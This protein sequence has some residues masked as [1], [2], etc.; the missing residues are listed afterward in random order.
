MIDDDDLLRHSL[1]FNLE[2]ARYRVSPAASAEDGLALAQRDRPDL[3]VLD[4]G[5][6]NMNGLDA[7]RHFRDELAVGII[8]LT[9]RRP[10]LDL[11]LGLKLGADDDVT[12]PFDLDVL[13]PAS[14]QFSG[15]RNMLLQPLPSRT[16]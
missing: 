7:L 13:S 3:I 12:K 1:A 11:V 6:P 8:V 15:A 14:R 9:A 16:R 2:R 5:L 4:L 10:E